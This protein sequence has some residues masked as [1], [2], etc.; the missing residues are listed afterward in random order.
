MDFDQKAGVLRDDGNN[1]GDRSIYK[2]LL[3]EDPSE[4]SLEGISI[5]AS[6]L[7]TIDIFGFDGVFLKMEEK[8]L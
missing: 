8:S 4:P 3:L 6:I 2:L 5:F 1:Y 7:S